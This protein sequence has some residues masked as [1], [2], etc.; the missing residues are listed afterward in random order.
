MTHPSSPGARPR[1]LTASDLAPQSWS[2]G[3]VIRHGDCDPAGIVYTPQFFDLFNQAIET[4]FCERLGIDYYD[5]IG[6]R[7]LGLGY[8]EAASIFFTPCMMGERLQIHVAVER[9]GSS[10]YTLVLHAMKDGHEALRGR[11]T[12]VVTCLKKHRPVEIPADIRTALANYGHETR[13]SAA[14]KVGT[15]PEAYHSTE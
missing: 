3:I 14:D 15:G 10:S 8:A 2:T 6:P 9:V 12:T 4:W 1:P 7:R 13:L 11:F 5:V